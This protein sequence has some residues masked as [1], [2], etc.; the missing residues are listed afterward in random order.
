MKIWFVS[1]THG[2]HAGLKVPKADVVIHCG[3]ESTHGNAWMNEPEAREFFEWYSALAIPTKLFIP[4]NHST[5]IEQGLIRPD[6]YP[7][8]TFLIHDATVVSGLKIFGSPYTPKFFDWA[9]MKPRTEI[10][11]VWKSIP[12]DVDILI[13]HGPPREIL[14]ITHDIQTGEPVHVGSGTLLQHVEERIR[15]KIH[16][17]GHIHDER[18]IQNFGTI[19]RGTTQFINCACCDL[20]GRLVHD[21]IVVNLDR[22]VRKI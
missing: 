17:F 10:E 11:S 2:V 8:V 15:P 1:D 9:Y 16:A 14:D 12:S 6:E 21:G 20:G 19:Q 18:G 7:N 22:P 5:A 13:T 4:G 3:D